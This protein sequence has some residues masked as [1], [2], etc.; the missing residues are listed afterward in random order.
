M[1]DIVEMHYGHSEKREP[2]PYTWSGLEDIYLCSG[3]DRIPVDDG[4]EDIVIHDMDGLHRAIG[5]YLVTEKKTLGGKE[6]R[7]LRRQ[8]DLTQ[9]DLG[10]LLR[11]TD[12][13]VARWEKGEN[14]FKGPAD[15]LLRAVYLAHLSEKV[16]VR[17]LAKELRA[18]DSPVSHHA[19][20]SRR[21]KDGWQLNAA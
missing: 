4:T 12:Q 7:F 5:H 15:L 16:D 17:E 19:I 21:Q 10:D 1:T 18:I 3:Y 2:L 8:M 13:S 11:V 9:A 14:S 20:F 6:V